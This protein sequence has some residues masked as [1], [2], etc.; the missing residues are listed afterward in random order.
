MLFPPFRTALQRPVE[1]LYFQLAAWAF[2]KVGAAVK[3]NLE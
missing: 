2:E 1:K 3:N